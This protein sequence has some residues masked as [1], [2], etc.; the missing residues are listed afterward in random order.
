[1]ASTAAKSWFPLREACCAAATPQ[2]LLCRLSLLL[3]PRPI[4]SVPPR[5][6][7]LH[8]VSSSIASLL[9]CSHRRDCCRKLGQRGTR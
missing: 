4:G 3:H 2:G 1:M 7:L 5:P 6:L 9:L 8:M